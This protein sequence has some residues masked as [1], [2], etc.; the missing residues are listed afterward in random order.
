MKVMGVFFMSCRNYSACLIFV[1]ISFLGLVKKYDTVPGK[2]Y[3]VIDSPIH[4]EQDDANF[5][6]IC[7]SACKLQTF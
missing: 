5:N 4:S 6:S 7:H 2:N 3:P 1:L